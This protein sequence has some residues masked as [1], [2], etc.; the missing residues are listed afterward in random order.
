MNY[1]I[2]WIRIVSLHSIF[3]VLYIREYHSRNRVS[4]G[5]L[6]I[7]WL[8]GNDLIKDIRVLAY[9]VCYQYQPIKVVFK[10]SNAEKDGRGGLE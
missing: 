4:I 9:I 8:A 1:C 6:P 2:Q 7:C 3:A 10:E 5:A